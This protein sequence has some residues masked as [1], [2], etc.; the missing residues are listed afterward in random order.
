MQ[1]NI[2]ESFIATLMNIGKTKDGL[3]SQKYMVQLNMKKELHPVPEGNGKYT[4]LVASFNLTLEERRVICTFVKGDQSSDR[5]FIECE[6]ASVNERPISEK[7]QGSRL[8]YDADSVP[9]HFNQ[10]YKARVFEN[11]H[12]PHVLLLYEDLIEGGGRGYFPIGGGRQLLLPICAGPIH[13]GDSIVP[14]WWQFAATIS[15]LRSACTTRSGGA[16]LG[17]VTDP[18]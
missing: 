14:R 9:T 12:P 4:L 6:K 16:G 5:V 3:K 8:S 7:L 10:G 15:S 17:A 2:F 13:G 1:K 18:R 11:G